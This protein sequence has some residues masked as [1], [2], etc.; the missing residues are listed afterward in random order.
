MPAKSKAQQHA[1]GAALSAKRGDT[2]FVQAQGRLARD[3]RQHDRRR[4]SR[5]SPRPT[6]R[7]FRSTSTPRTDVPARRAPRRRGSR[8]LC[9]KT[10]Q[11]PAGA[12]SKMGHRA[13]KRRGRPARAVFRAI[14][15]AAPSLA[16]SPGF[17]TVNCPTWQRPH[18]CIQPPDML[19]LPDQT[20][21]TARM[22]ETGMRELC[23]GRFDGQ[24]AVGRVFARRPRSGGALAAALAL[25]LLGH[26]CPRSGAER[27]RLP[28]RHD[29]IE[30]D[31]PRGRREISE[32]SR[33]LARDSPLLRDQFDRRPRARA[34]SS[35][36]RST[37][38]RRPTRR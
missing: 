19:A 26:H 2:P 37:R 17:A 18:N 25:V 36:S 28:D 9:S 4:N 15:E 6:G 5:S 14:P 8:P 12:V 20:G 7:T 23:A 29:R 30:R 10:E 1:A 38:S 33:P 21:A 31:D 16:R 35:A 24:S 32:R 27:R 13:A 3:V 11:R 22:G 34:W